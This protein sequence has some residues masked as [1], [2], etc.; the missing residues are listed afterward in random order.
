MSARDDLDAAM[1]SAF[2][3]ET[4]E[5]AA[6]FDAYRDEILREAAERIRVGADDIV[7]ALRREYPYIDGDDADKG[8]YGAADFI[9]PEVSP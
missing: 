6:F 1:E 5:T 9:D 3:I 8:L 4:H 2:G 7:D